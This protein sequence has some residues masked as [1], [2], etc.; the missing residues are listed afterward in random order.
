[1]ENV[2]LLQ[3]L[4]NSL[5]GFVWGF[6][7]L[8][9]DTSQLD[10]GKFYKAFDWFMDFITKLDFIL[11]VDTMTTIIGLTFGLEAVIFVVWVVRFIIG[12]IRGM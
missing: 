9:P 10:M 2:G 6:C 5:V 3:G 11:P 12:L 8:L 7:D 4:V 1:M